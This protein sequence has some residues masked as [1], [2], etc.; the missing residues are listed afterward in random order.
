MTFGD[1]RGLGRIIPEVSKV[2]PPRNVP[3]PFLKPVPVPELSLNFGDGDKEFRGLGTALASL[4]RTICIMTFFLP[5]FVI[6]FHQLPFFLKI[7]ANTCILVHSN[8]T[9]CTSKHISFPSPLCVCSN[10]TWDGGVIGKNSICHP[11][12][13]PRSSSRLLALLSY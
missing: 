9:L 2:S 6:P 13:R 5:D 11:R 1:F 8:P 7:K 12:S 3:K 4:V 10:S